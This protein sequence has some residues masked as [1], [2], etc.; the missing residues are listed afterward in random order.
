MTLVKE[1]MKETEFERYEIEQDFDAFIKMAYG[2]WGLSVETVSGC[3]EVNNFN[4]FQIERRGEHTAST[5]TAGSARRTLGTPTILSVDDRY[6]QVTVVVTAVT[7]LRVE[8]IMGVFESARDT[9]ALPAPKPERPR[10]FIGHGG[11]PA[12]QVT[13]LYLQQFGFEVREYESLPHTGRTIERVLTDALVWSNFALLIMTAEDE[14]ADQSVQARLNVVHEL[15]LFQGQLGW[16]QA[17]VLLEEGAS[18]FS[19]IA[20]TNQLRF[21]KGQIA[22]K[23]GDIMLA[24]RERFP[25]LTI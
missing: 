8:R 14:M 11:N 17:L 23:H 22:A 12:W 21:P 15:G 6:S 13:H 5:F 19:N 10:I 20:G 7:R 25:G 3:W 2:V 4:E 18:E 9:S 24:L 16:D 1:I